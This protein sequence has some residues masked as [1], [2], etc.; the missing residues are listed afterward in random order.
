MSSAAT[1]QER[2]AGLFG[3]VSSRHTDLSVVR[4]EGARL[5]TEN[6]REIVDF[7]SGVAVTNVGHNHPAVV[8]AARDQM[9]QLV[10][11]GHNV[12]LYPSYV[13][14]AERLVELVG[15]G[16][17]VFYGN[18]GAEAVEAAVKLALRATGRP[19]L[20]AFKHSFHGRTIA[21]TALSASAAA[22]RTGYSAALPAVQ[23]V[24]Y[25]SP[26]AR[27][28]T[29][30]EEV[31]RCL[32]QLDEVF[33]LTLAADEVAAIVVEPFQGEGGYQPAPA[34]FL[35][36][37]RERADRH[38]IVLVYDEIQSGFGRTGSM[39]FYEQLGVAPDV[40]VLAKGIANGFPLSAIVASADLMDRWPAGAHGGTFG[41]NPV[42]CA[43]AL[44]VIQVLQS[45]AMDNA[46][47]RGEELMTGLRSI[48]D[49]LPMRAQVRGAGAMIGVELR[50]QD[51]GTA[52]DMVSALRRAA[53]ERGLLLLACGP[54]KT[55]LRLMPPTTLTAE[56]ATRALAILDDALTE[57]LPSVE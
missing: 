49:R 46:R 16:Q 36:G 30:E 15:D 40:L 56:E 41:G 31:K 51:G 28:A 25:P 53:L 24:D 48:V 8:Q 43:A 50:R 54:D 22:Q 39:F 13:T 44:A 10:H 4:A 18:S 14:L 29:V 32:A 42:A 55:T 17:K 1:L 21:A 38:G 20:V 11:A 47:L 9:D 45:G 57:V 3:P 37:L 26:F 23:H 27:G 33:A 5:W 2:A 7:A 19:G 34:E 12:G 35:R 6:G 52:G